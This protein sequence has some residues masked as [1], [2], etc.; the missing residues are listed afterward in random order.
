M[1]S[2]KSGNYVHNLNLVTWSLILIFKKK[3][4]LNAVQCY[5][6]PKS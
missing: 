1:T 4:D 6:L 3:S 5:Q 2:S